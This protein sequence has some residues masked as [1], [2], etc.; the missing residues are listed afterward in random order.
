M[1]LALIYFPFAKLIL[2]ANFKSFS[3]N[4]LSN[5]WLKIKF[6]IE[7][8]QRKW[9]IKIVIIIPEKLFF[10]KT[11]LFRTHFHLIQ[12]I[13]IFFLRINQ[14]FI[15][16]KNFRVIQILFASQIFNCLPQ[17]MVVNRRKQIFQIAQIHI[18][19]FSKF[20]FYLKIQALFN[21]VGQKPG[22]GR[23]DF[24]TRLNLPSYIQSIHSPDKIT[25]ALLL[26]IPSFNQQKVGI[27]HILPSQRNFV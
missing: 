19:R 5:A 24:K 6:K 26:F 23:I 4:F 3:P 27:P 22:I 8:I 12:L 20:L 18:S 15:I 10:V 1:N 21:K 17:S 13:F 14:I 2:S 11:N 9:I 7:L 16:L 25:K